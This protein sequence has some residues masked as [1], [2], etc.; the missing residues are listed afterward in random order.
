MRGRRARVLVGLVIVMLM[1]TAVYLR[2]WTIDYTVSSADTELLR[3]AMDESAEWRLKYDKQVERVTKCTQELNR[4][5][6]SF[7]KQI[8]DPANINQKIVMLQ[9]ENKALLERIKVLNQQLEAQ[10]MKCS[11]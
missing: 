4:V 2:L 6:E 8:K 7:E 3:E 10:K 11:S 1:G 9:K 5:K